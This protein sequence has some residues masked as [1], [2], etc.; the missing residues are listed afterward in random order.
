MS[1]IKRMNIPYIRAGAIA[2]IIGGI[3]AALLGLLHL[4]SLYGAAETTAYIARG[5]LLAFTIVVLARIAARPLA[6]VGAVLAVTGALLQ[7]AMIVSAETGIA[8]DFEGPLM[9]VSLLGLLVGQILLGIAHFR[10]RAL[11]VWVSAAIALGI[12]LTVVPMVGEI[13]YGALFAAIGLSMYGKATA[14][15]VPAH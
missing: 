5:L 13:L 14:E 11:P 6:T 15:V 12:L 10:A 7:V 1:S 4:L 8:V 2:A 3:A 9:P